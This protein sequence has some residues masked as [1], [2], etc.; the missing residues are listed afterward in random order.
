[1]QATA[2][3][4]LRVTVC[5]LGAAGLQLDAT[6]HDSVLLETDVRGAEEVAAGAERLMIR[7]SAQVL[8][9]PLRVDCKI[10]R[11]GK[12]LLEPGG[13]S[14]TWDRVWRLLAQLPPSRLFKAGDA[15]T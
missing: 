7:A 15:F 13:P 5:A 11:P 2:G 6:V 8:G 1:V 14:R 3:D 10:I 4:V 9:E 12:R